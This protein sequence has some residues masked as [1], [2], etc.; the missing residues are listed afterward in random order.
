MSFPLYAKVISGL[1][2]CAIFSTI[3]RN[4]PLEN[5]QQTR[6]SQNGPEQIV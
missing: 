3:L 6:I 1:E 2:D 4:T 5:G